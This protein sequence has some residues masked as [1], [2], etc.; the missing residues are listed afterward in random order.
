MYYMEKIIA[1]V[2]TDDKVLFGLVV[3]A[4]VAPTWM[5]W[6]NARITKQQIAQSRHRSIEDHDDLANK[7]NDIQARLGYHS[8][9]IEIINVRQQEMQVNQK[10]MKTNQEESMKLLIELKDSA[11]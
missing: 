1:S 9:Q 8:G 6:W 10:E 5:A 3:T 2:H 11:A 4:L 7:M